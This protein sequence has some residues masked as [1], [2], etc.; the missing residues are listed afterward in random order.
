MDK[1]LMACLLSEENL[2]KIILSPVVVKDEPNAYIVKFKVGVQQFMLDGYQ[3]KEESEWMGK[4]LIKA[5]ETV[6]KAQLQSSKLKA[7]I[8]RLVQ[9]AVKAERERVVSRLLTMVLSLEQNDN[10]W[11]PENA[12]V[13]QAT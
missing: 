11:K 13:V 6:A 3:T 12:E 10:E 9:E 7:Y 2:A 5:F 8:D 1:E 4:M